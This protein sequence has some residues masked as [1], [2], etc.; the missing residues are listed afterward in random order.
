MPNVMSNGKNAQPVTGEPIE[1]GTEET[2]SIAL[3]LA[4]ESAWQE[5]SRY[6]VEMPP[7]DFQQLVSDLLEAMG[8]PHRLGR[9]SRTG[10][11]CGHHRRD[12]PTRRVRPKDQ[13][14]GQ[15]PSGSRFRGRRLLVHGR[16][17]V[18]RHRPT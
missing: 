16:S 5:I 6:L 3:E 2:P 9:P 17:R 8:Y 7:Y 13:G 12:R 10:Q 15:A 14:A 18:K 11:G 4:E 1:D